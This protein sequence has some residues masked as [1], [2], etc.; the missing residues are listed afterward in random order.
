ML[1]N[2]G[3]LLI[4]NTVIFALIII[5]SIII[6]VYNVN[7]IKKN[8]EDFK[9]SKLYV[10]S[11]S[12]NTIED[13]QKML[14]SFIDE[15]FQD[16]LA[17]NPEYA[18]YDDISS[19]EELKIRNDVGNIVSLRLSEA[20]LRKLSLYYNDKVIASIIADKIYIKVTAFVISTNKNTK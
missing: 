7:M 5:L 4:I 16:Y 8:D 12:N 17:K 14:E 18:T 10:E 1:S 9:K 19:D 15:C 13:I 3:I 11:L 2:V 6:I 20:L